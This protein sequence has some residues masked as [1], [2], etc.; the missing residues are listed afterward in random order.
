M[1]LGAALGTSPIRRVRVVAALISRQDRLLIQ[2]RPAGSARAGLW[3]F[4]GGKTEEGET[5]QEA[6]ARE[7][8]E[9][10]GVAVTVGPCLWQGEHA[11]EDL[12][13]SLALFSC[14]LSV[15]EPRGLCGQEIAW[16]D[17]GRLFDYA[18]VA[19]D[20]PLLG[21]LSRGEL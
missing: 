10:L 5:D 17:R 1:S 19:A 4:P 8:R 2:Q 21:P 18:F 14:S 6:L 7:C 9:E 15:G 11:Y 16:A 12:A 20:A 13:V 3:E